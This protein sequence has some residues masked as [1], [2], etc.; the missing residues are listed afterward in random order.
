[1]QWMRLLSIS[2]GSA[3]IWARDSAP[4]EPTVREPSF[5]VLYLRL[6]ASALRDSSSVAVC[7]GRDLAVLAVSA[8]LASG[9]GVFSAPRGIVGTSHQCHTRREIAS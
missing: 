6:S 4:A 8:A 5:D 3:C 9:L 2:P 7:D 1:M